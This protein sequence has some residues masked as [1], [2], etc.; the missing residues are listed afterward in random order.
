MAETFTIDTGNAVMSQPASGGRAV[1]SNQQG[2]AL[3]GG[4]PAAQQVDTSLEQGTVQALL[5]LG[6]DVLQPAIK[7]EASRQFMTGVEQAATGEAIADI[8]KDRPWYTE[9]FGPSSAVQGARAYTVAQTIAKFGAD[10]EAQMPVLARQG[11]EAMTAAMENMRKPLLT[12]DAIADMA[13]T[14]QIVDQMAPLYKRHAKEHYIHQQKVASSAQVDAWTS[15]AAAYQQRAQ[16]ATKPD[17]GVTPE[18]VK[19]DADR[20]IGA[21]APFADQGDDSYERNVG[22]FLEASATAGNFQVVKLF[23]EKGLFDQLPPETRATLD[24]T[25]KVAGRA[26][27]DK[28]MP[29]YALDVALLVNDTAQDPRGVVDRMRALNAKAAAATGVTEAEL[30]PMSTADNIIGNVLR[31]QATQ[32]RAVQDQQAA[33]AMAASQL[34]VPG[35]AGPCKETGLCKETA[36]EQAA[37]LKFNASQD[38]AQKAQMLNNNGT[39]TFGAIKSNM[40]AMMNTKEDTPGMQS[41][42]QL[43]M[44]MNESTRGRYFLADEQ[45]FLDRYTA[46]IQAGQQPAAAFQSAKV[47]QPIAKYY[48][49]PKEKTETAQAIRSWVE[50]E[51][52]RGNGVAGWFGA[53]GIDDHG[54]KVAETV[55]GASVA[56]N[57]GLNSIPASVA[58]A[59]S[60]A[61]TTGRLQIIGERAIIGDFSNQKPITEILGTGENNMGERE[62]AKVF[63]HVL[64]DK[65]AKA[66]AK[67]IGEYTIIRTPDFSGKARFEVQVMDKDFAIKVF[68]IT[69]D[70]MRAAN[71]E[72][73]KTPEKGTP[74][75]GYPKPF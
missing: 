13:I 71:A 29:D 52:E 67:D 45:K 26:A 8:V 21:M 30:I 48:L 36:I 24:R 35:G 50:K 3:P 66:G 60:E 39:L 56:Q 75:I 14:S 5:K 34:D 63:D 53:N 43:Y 64:V 4:V 57:R 41:L 54:L 22:R 28:V 6:S 18:D 46:A 23:K 72:L 27:L 20:L 31:T 10:M 12:G 1:L 15:L 58:R 17:G 69:S 65:A 32:G 59:L 33:F 61:R 19:A 47:V 73:G 25:F 42:G 11:P 51:A 16:A 37:L 38:V 40:A 9:I 68:T 49:D 70:E 7:A 44:Q 74:F 62:I 55:V 2:A